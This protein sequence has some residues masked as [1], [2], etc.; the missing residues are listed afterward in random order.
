MLEQGEGM[1]CD[2]DMETGCLWTREPGKE[3]HVSHRPAGSPQDGFLL[4]NWDTHRA[5]GP[6]LTCTHQANQEDIS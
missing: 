2:G 4:R 5:F 3:S 1:L 6:L